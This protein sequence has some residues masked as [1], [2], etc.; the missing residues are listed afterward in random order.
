MENI[1]SEDIGEEIL[2]KLEELNKI[3]E[4]LLKERENAKKCTLACG[5]NNG[6][7]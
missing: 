1:A 5:C 7:S 3:L 6:I 4:K 2:S